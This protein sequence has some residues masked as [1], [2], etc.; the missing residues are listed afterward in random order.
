MELLRLSTRQMLFR[1]FSYSKF[2]N[3]INS[4]NRRIVNLLSACRLY[5]DHSSHHL[6]NIF[7]GDEEKKNE[8]KSYA[9]HEYDT[10]LG[11]RVMEALRNYVQH[12]GFPVQRCTYNSKRVEDKEHNKVLFSLTPYLDVVKLKED[13]KFKKVVLEEL[14]TIGEKHDIKPLLREYVSS[15]SSIHEKNRALLAEFTGQWES[16]FNRHIETFKLET[17]DDSVV[18]LA[19]VI[20]GENGTYNSPVSIFFE[21]IKHRRELERKNGNLKSLVSH[22]VTSE[23]V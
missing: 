16:T 19:A 11:Y 18:G 9:S 7:N 4:V 21:L 13:G 14:E 12:R 8:V 20:S 1:D 6:S 15:I 2:Q 10:A 17:G 3:E 5:I 23:V 22:Y